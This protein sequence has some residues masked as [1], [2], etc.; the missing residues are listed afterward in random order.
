MA[1]LKGFLEGL[2]KGLPLLAQIFERRRQEGLAREDEERSFMKRLQMMAA[3]QGLPLETIEQLPREQ[4]ETIS[5]QVAGFHPTRQVYESEK[6]GRRRF[7]D[8]PEY[9]EV[10][11]EMV[12]YG[13]PSSFDAGLSETVSPYGGE[14]RRPAT[15]SEL[16]SRIGLRTGEDRAFEQEMKRRQIESLAQSRD[17]EERLKFEQGKRDIMTDSQ[18]KVLSKTQEGQRA[19]QEMRAAARRGEILLSQAGQQR[20]ADMRLVGA[21]EMAENRQRMYQTM[22]LNSTVAK[23]LRQFDEQGYMLERAKELLEKPNVQEN[24]GPVYGRVTQYAAYFN[25]AEE[26]ALDLQAIMENM[27]GEIRHSRFGGQLTVNEAKLAERFLPGPNDSVQELQ[28]K[29]RNLGEILN[30]AR[31]RVMQDVKGGSILPV[32]SIE[33][34]DAELEAIEKEL[35]GR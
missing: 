15:T 30:M 8:N 17:P 7:Y 6:V 31:A 5:P 9:E 28:V 22:N 23:E 21:K 27:A 26:E 19:L 11:K 14:K 10:G 34:I 20:L 24:L 1:N 18:L 2:N 13:D 25:M 3:Q 32:E 16:L 29:F 35:G 12:Q 33:D 4:L